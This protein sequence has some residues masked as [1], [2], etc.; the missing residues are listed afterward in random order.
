MPSPGRSRVILVTGFE[1]FG[2]HAVNPSEGLA[3]ALEGRAIGG[4]PI[5]TA[6][7]PVHHRETSLRI[8]A[9]LD[10]VDPTDVLHL[11]LAD[12]R[13]RL[14]LERVALNVR[15]FPIP[16]N[17][18]HRAA[19]EAC[20]P[21]G[22]AAYLSTLPLRAILAALR[23]DGIPAYLSNTA[24]TYLCNQTLYAT[25]HAIQR[26]GGRARAGFLHLPALP[27]MVAAR[28][29]DQPSMDFPLMLRGVEVA[30]GVLA[31]APDA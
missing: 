7:L 21:G 26:R 6:V 23:L 22:P 15:D 30:L 28:D 19:G 25:L 4:V 1:P 13:A 14:A 10:E 9:L 18:G 5:V 11:G 24:G 20:V 17:A 31:G 27:K 12:G 16:D 2:D 3:K 8:T 29:L